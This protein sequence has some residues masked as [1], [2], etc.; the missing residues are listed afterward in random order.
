MS[1]SFFNALLTLLAF[2]GFLGTLI[3]FIYYWLRY[4]RSDC[5]KPTR[6]AVASTAEAS[7]RFMVWSLLA[8][9]ILAIAAAVWGE[10]GIKSLW[11]ILALLGI[12]VLT[13]GI[14]YV[15]AKVTRSNS[16]SAHQPADTE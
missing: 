9:W 10:Y 8:I 12:I 2:L 15:V 4:L 13:L 16:D 6:A 14:T 3:I 1:D 5:A 7:S 11:T